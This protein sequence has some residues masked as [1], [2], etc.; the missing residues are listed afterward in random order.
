VRQI[1]IATPNIGREKIEWLKILLNNDQ[2]ARKL[3]ANALGD[4][5]YQSIREHLSGI[6]QEPQITSRIGQKLESTIDGKTILGYE[7]SVIT[8]DI[9][10][11]GPKSLEKLIG[12]DLYVGISVNS[13]G[14]IQTKGFLT[15]AKIIG[16]LKAQK[17]FDD[18]DDACTQM[19]ERS[20]S[21]YDWLYENSGVRV[22]KAEDVLKR[23]ARDPSTWQRGRASTVFSRTLE[24]TEGDFGIGLPSVWGRQMTQRAALGEML[25]KLRVPKG[26][27]ISIRKLKI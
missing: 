16:K 11:R 13:G 26:I 19:L 1:K 12:A 22:I 10:D 3:I 7:L 24:C 4:A 25:E 21:S 17:D 23:T 2:I 9:P 8:Q 18:L 15:Q 27:G 6:S 5:V 20:D 14:N